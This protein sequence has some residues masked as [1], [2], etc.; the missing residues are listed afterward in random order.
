MMDQVS[1]VKR[2]IRPSVVVDD[3]TKSFLVAGSQSDDAS[4]VH[5]RR[6]SDQ[7]VDALRGVS[8]FVEPGESVGLIGL[9]GS[10]KSTL[11]RIISGGEAPTTGNVY[12]T[13]RPVLLGVSPALQ[14]D[15]TGKQN[16]YLGC[17]ALGMSPQEATDQVTEIGEWTELGAALD[18]PMSTYSSGMGARLSF[19]ISTA[20]EPDILLI[21][22]A[23]STGDAAFAARAEERMNNLLERAGTLFIVSH[24]AGTIRRL[25][26]RVIWLSHGEVI[27][28]GETEPVLNGYEE[29]VR[30]LKEEGESE[31]DAFLASFSD[32]YQRPRFRYEPHPSGAH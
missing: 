20:L 2:H 22:E 30:V 16:I 8:F 21:D 17:L 9:N 23:L 10:G 13:S 11:L 26:D 15:L 19:A 3:V 32:G 31:A 18:R 25:C 4:T 12:A 24:G 27:G 28:D 14:A 5:V 7:R 6:S 29:W 1:I